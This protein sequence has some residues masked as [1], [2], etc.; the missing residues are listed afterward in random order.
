MIKRCNDFGV[1][2]VC[3]VIGEI[4]DSLDINLDLVFKKYDGFDGIEFVI[5]E[6]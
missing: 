1:G 2:G 5:L 3:V 6:L 4:V